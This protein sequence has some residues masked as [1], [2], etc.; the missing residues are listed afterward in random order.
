MSINVAGLPAMLERG[1]AVNDRIFVIMRREILELIKLLRSSKATG[2]QAPIGSR[3]LLE[4]GIGR[5]LG[6]TLLLPPPVN[7]SMTQCVDAT[8]FVA[9]LCGTALWHCQVVLSV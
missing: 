3:E 1:T 5:V 7:E 4:A 2:E 8:C 9:L 6:M